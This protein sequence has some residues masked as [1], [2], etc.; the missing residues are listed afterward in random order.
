MKKQAEVVVIGAGIMGA[1]LA[2][3]LAKHGKEVLVLEQN[4]ICSGTSSS[5]AAWLWP[6]DKTPLHYGKLAWDGYNRYMT[7]AEELGADF[8]LT[9]TGGVE[10]LYTEEEVRAAEKTIQVAHS[11]GHPDVRIVSQ[12]EVQEIEPILRHDILGAIVSPYE[13]H[14]NPF[15]LVNAYIQAAK[16]LGAEVST[17]TK[18]E[19]FVVKGNH[20][21]EIVTNKGTVKPGLVICAAGIYS[22]KI[23]EM[24]GLDAH[25]KPERG[26]CLVSEKMPKIL[27]NVI[28]GA[29]Q[30]V[31]G[32]IIFGFIADKVPMDCI[33]R[34]MYIRGLQWAAKDAV[35][36]FPTLQNINIIRS[37]T[38]IRCKP[39]DKFPIIGP[40]GK[41]DNFWFHLAHSAFAHNPVLS[42]YVAEMVA[43]ER[44]YDSLPEYVYTRFDK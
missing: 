13:G 21:E 33:D 43:G 23:G 19:N 28:V 27:N 22:R 17:Y 11:L 16:R 37:Y 31:S 8:E 30:T 24:V 10:P 9:I 18:V 1:S 15:L 36:D 20:I 41:I 39:E 40:T 38:G 44:P 6:T 14:L 25:V 7:L 4:E 3:F 5:T 26:F 35:R 2:Y 32:N 34:R 12:K 29:R 42:D